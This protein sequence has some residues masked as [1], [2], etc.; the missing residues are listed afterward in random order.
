MKTGVCGFCFPRG[1]PFV[2]QVS[3]TARAGFE[4][5]EVFLWDQNELDQGPAGT[6]HADVPAILH[7][8]GIQA[9]GVTS[10][11]LW[12]HTFTSPDSTN[13]KQA[14]DIAARLVELAVLYG[15]RSALVIPGVLVPGV[16]YRKAWELAVDSFKRL[17]PTA[18]KA[19]VTLGL[20]NGGNKFLLAPFEFANFLDEIGSDN[21]GAYLDTANTML[22]HGVPADWIEILGPRLAQV[23]FKDFG[24]GTRPYPYCGLL[25]GSVDWP[26]VLDALKKTGYDGWAVAEVPPYV[27]NYHA[28][29]AHTCDALKFL[30]GGRLAV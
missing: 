28:S 16:T 1:T 6:P 9:C 29:I 22:E 30:L 23:H 13:R 20:E 17:A 19:G 8:A 14:E 2:E 5:L 4:G 3:I 24:S 21:I 25:H 10:V 26:A 12:A 7:D 15:A 27:G 11:L 18:E